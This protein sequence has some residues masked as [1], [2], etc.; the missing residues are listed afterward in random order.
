MV[1][2]DKCIIKINNSGIMANS[3]NI[4]ISPNVE[5]IYGIGKKN[6]FSQSKVGPLKNSFRF[7]YLM[8][9]NQEPNYGVVEMI[10]NL[11][12]SNSYSGLQ[13]EV[14]GVTGYNCFLNSYDFSAQ[15][16][17]LI[18][19]STN[20]ESFTPVS[21]ELIEKNQTFTFN[22][23]NLAHGWACFIN[24]TG[25]YLEN[26]IL[27][28]NYNFNATW[29]PIY[30]LGRNYPVEYHLMSATE[31]FSFDRDIFYNISDTGRN[32]LDSFFSN[33]QI[34]LY[35][36]NYLCNNTNTGINFT[37]D[38]ASGKITQTELNSNLDD[39]IR[40]STTVKKVY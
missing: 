22:T 9:I 3:A 33:S 14:G 15:P 39:I 38:V 32:V 24:N 17:G 37:F 1:F 7:N 12:I 19:I 21:G 29:Q 8:E 25:N 28:F 40:V 18:S 13:L 2:F 20:F 30:L 26:K 11:L 35:T 36:L 10:K 6:I 23:G 16:N 4:S 5:A 31:D 34:K 27:S